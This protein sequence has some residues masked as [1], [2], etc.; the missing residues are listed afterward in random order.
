MNEFEINNNRSEIHTHMRWKLKC[1]TEERNMKIHSTKVIQFFKKI[2]S[3]AN[4]DSH[5]IQ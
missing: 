3:Q 4:N 5:L 1:F 2:H